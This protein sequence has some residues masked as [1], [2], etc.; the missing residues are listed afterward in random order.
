MLAVADPDAARAQNSRWTGAGDGQ[1]WTDDANWD[2]PPDNTLNVYIDNGGTAQVQ[3]PG[4]EAVRV[5]VGDGNS[6]GSLE[7]TSGGTLN[8]G[9]SGTIGD[10]PGSTGTVTVTGGGSTW[11]KIGRATCR[12][13]ACQSV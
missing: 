5:I 8:N 12:A 1:S 13:R 4:A 3:A 2:A 9:F 7:I 10:D 11:A 6:S